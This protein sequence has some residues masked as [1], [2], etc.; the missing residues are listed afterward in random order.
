[1]QFVVYIIWLLIQVCKSRMFLVISISFFYA[2]SFSFDYWFCYCDTSIKANLIVNSKHTKASYRCLCCFVNVAVALI[3][4]SSK[5]FPVHIFFSLFTIVVNLINI[6]PRR[7][8][9]YLY[10]YVRVCVYIYSVGKY[11]S[12]TKR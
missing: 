2:C 10:M 5:Y 9:L 12:S 6:K 8:W 4:T 3:F 7:H 1:M 11:R